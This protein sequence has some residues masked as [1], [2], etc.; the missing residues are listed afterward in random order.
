MRL[1]YDQELVNITI[2]QK[3][4]LTSNVLIKLPLPIATKLNVTA[5]TYIRQIMSNQ[6]AKPLLNDINKY[7]VE[8]CKSCN[9]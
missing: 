5:L 9:I 2:K 6:N 4:L 1:Y 3:Y 7:Q 8:E